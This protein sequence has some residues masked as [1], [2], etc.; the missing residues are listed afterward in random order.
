MTKKTASVLASYARSAL[1]SVL[2][3]A[4][5]VSSSTG[6][7]PTAWNDAEWMSL[8][9][10]LWIAAIPVA[11]RWLNPKDPAFGRNAATETSN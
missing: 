3:A 1:A 2:A 8:I 5:T 9:N 11:I 7:I 10:V 6:K 4:V